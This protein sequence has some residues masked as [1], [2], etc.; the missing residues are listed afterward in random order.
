MLISIKFDDEYNANTPGIAVDQ[1]DEDFNVFT[2]IN[3]NRAFKPAP[4]TTQVEDIWQGREA[5]PRCLQRKR[6]KL[7]LTPKIGV[8]FS[9]SRF[10]RR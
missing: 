4:N 8:N 10:Y 1:F 2:K 6:E 9:F 3:K 7:K 5:K